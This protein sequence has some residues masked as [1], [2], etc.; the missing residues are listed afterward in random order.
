MNDEKID[1]RDLE[2]F[3]DGLKSTMDT[4]DGVD[5]S[6]SK[7]FQAQL[8]KAISNLTIRERNERRY[9]EI[10]NKRIRPIKSIS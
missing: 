7:G 4:L 3:I 6:K 2:A 8:A 5:P 10:F 1:I 9:K